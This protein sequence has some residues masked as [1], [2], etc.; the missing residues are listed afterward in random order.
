MEEVVST[1]DLMNSAPLLTICTHGKDDDYMGDFIYRLTTTI[2]LLGTHLS[3]IEMTD[4][5][6]VLIVDWG[7]KKPLSESVVFC[8]EACIISKF[9]HVPREKILATQE[10]KDYYHTTRAINV[11]VR[12]A[13]GKFIFITSPDQLFSLP[14]I[15]RLLMV[16]QKKVLLGVDVEDA[17]LVVPRI[18][19][20]W[21]MAKRQPTIQEWGNFLIHNEYA[22]DHEPAVFKHC[23]GVSSGFIMSAKNIRELGGFDEAQRGWGW[24]DI[25]FGLRA[26]QSHR[27]VWL[28]NLGINMF[29][30]GHPPTGRRQV[31]LSQPNTARFTSSPV[32]NDPNWGLNDSQF[33]V[34]IATY[35]EDEY[36]KSLKRNADEREAE[37][38]RSI[39]SALESIAKGDP[40]GGVAFAITKLQMRGRYVYAK[41]RLFFLVLHFISRNVLPM[42]YAE[43]GFMDGFYA[44][45]VAAAMPCVE[46]VGIDLLEGES[47]DNPFITFLHYLDESGFKGRFQ[48]INASPK[49]AV[50]RL[51]KL[52]GPEPKYELIVLP[53][54]TLSLLDKKLLLSLLSPCGVVI[55]RE[56]NVKNR[57]LDRE[58]RKIGARVLTFDGGDCVIILKDQSGKGKLY[59]PRRSRYVVN[60]EHLAQFSRIMDGMPEDNRHKK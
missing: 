19:I 50:T 8:H 6:E 55:I 43:F 44:S 1:L 51:I 26:T 54:D 31:A 35:R 32:V 25:D 5:V 3:T 10:N 49:D 41:D 40:A 12:R 57:A 42:K 56:A 46:I 48:F 4:L 16:L 58:F 21:Q 33:Q 28:S 34:D 29:H 38:F 2:N 36:L 7:S 52:Y 27:Y 14:A 45:L 17:F 18:Q 60:K 37:F 13:Q 23:F 53:A 11:G 20:P 24:S 15:E 30:M 9:I 59:I 22:L 39:Q 47:N